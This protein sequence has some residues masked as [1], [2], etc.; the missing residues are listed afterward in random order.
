MNRRE[1]RAFKHLGGDWG[2]DERFRAAHAP[3]RDADAVAIQAGQH[4]GSPKEG[5]AGRTQGGNFD[6]PNW[7]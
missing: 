5:K 2:R 3:Q 6:A 1:R 7:R 4:F